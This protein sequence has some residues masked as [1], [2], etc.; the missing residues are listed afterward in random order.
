MEQTLKTLNDRLYGMCTLKGENSI[1]VLNDINYSLHKYTFK[2]EYFIS[3]FNTEMAT[4][5]DFK[6]KNSLESVI[7]GNDPYR[8]IQKPIKELIELFVSYHKVKVKEYLFAKRVKLAKEGYD[9][10]VKLFDI[11]AII[12]DIDSK[13]DGKD[14]K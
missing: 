6:G 14:T 13:L 5:V 12:S 2:D 3:Y 4:V 11:D 9:L 7:V 1:T 8:S 10:S